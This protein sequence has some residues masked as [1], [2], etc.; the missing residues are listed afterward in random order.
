MTFQ[1][2]TFAIAAV[3]AL[4]AA[5]PAVGQHPTPPVLDSLIKG[6]LPARGLYVFRFAANPRRMR[7]SFCATA[8]CLPIG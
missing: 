6:T 2:I 4:C 5:S 8:S 7:A 1:K 3:A